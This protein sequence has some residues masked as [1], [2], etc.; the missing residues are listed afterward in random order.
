MDTLTYQQ[1]HQYLS[2]LHFKEILSQQEQSTIRKQARNYFIQDNQ[3]Y[4]REYQ[5][6][7]NPQRLITDSERETILYSVYSDLTAGHFNKDATLEKTLNLYYWSMM[8]KDIFKYVV[9]GGFWS[10][11]CNVVDTYLL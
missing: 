2:T 10:L 7:S 3:L 8:H 6:H 4:R 11:F 1:L 5:N 9:T